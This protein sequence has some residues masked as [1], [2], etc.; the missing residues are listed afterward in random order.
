M[1]FFNYFEN[2]NNNN[3]E[4]EEIIREKI[5]EYHNKHLVSKIIGLSN[6]M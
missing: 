4:E 6:I 5:V 1:M 3:S 2:F